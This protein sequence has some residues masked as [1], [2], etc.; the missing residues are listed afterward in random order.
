LM[1]RYPSRR[2]KISPNRSFNSLAEVPDDPDP[3]QKEDF[4]VHFPGVANR[5]ARMAEYAARACSATSRT[6]ALAK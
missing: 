2:I 6:G 4:I 5:A 3:Y 1:D